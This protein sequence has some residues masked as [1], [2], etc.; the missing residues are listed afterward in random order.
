MRARLPTITSTS[1]SSPNRCR[2]DC[3]GDLAC[4]A[5][6]NAYGKEEGKR[7][8]S[9]ERSVPNSYWEFAMQK[10][11]HLC[12]AVYTKMVGSVTNFRH[13]AEPTPLPCPRLHLEHLVFELDKKFNETQLQLNLS[14]LLVRIQPLVS[15]SDSLSIPLDLIWVLCNSQLCSFEAALANWMCQSTIEYACIV[16]VPQTTQ[17]IIDQVLLGRLSDTRRIWWRWRTLSK[18]RCTWCWAKKRNCRG[19][20]TETTTASTCNTATDCVRRISHQTSLASEKV[21][22]SFNFVLYCSR[23]QV[24]SSA[25]R[26]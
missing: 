12:T 11:S 21:K 25:R 19:H 4:Q 8:A 3:H 9:T 10:A 24:P 23:P 18:A 22:F 20:D 16:E 14:P 15:I 5:D 17:N 26:L 6:Y 7:Q 1:T 2:P 13:Y